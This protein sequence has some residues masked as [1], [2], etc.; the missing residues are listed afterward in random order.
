MSSVPSQPS[1][2][3]FSILEKILNDHSSYEA[4][5]TVEQE[6]EELDQMQ[7]VLAISRKDSRQVAY[8]IPCLKLK[9]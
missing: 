5:S 3:C 7:K 4:D 9:F 6:E 1:D 8:C 2:P